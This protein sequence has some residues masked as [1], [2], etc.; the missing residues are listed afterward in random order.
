MTS[1]VSSYL[2]GK[3]I[4]RYKSGLHLKTVNYASSPLSP[5]PHSPTKRT[6]VPE[7]PNDAASV[8]R[9]QA[10][11]QQCGLAP[12]PGKGLSQ[13]KQELDPRFCQVVVLPQEQPELA[14]STTARREWQM[15]NELSDDTGT[16]DPNPLASDSLYLV[17]PDKSDLTR[18]AEEE[19]VPA[20]TMS[21]AG[22]GA[23]V[24]KGEERRISTGIFQSD[25]RDPGS[26]SEKSAGSELQ[27]ATEQPRLKSTKSKSVTPVAPQPATPALPLVPP[28]PVRRPVVVVME[29]LE[30]LIQAVNRIEDDESRRLT[31]IAFLS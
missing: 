17:H 15:E 9:R 26:D 5:P 27:P 3:L 2:L 18:N 22:F 13:L 6:G 21:S 12:R 23:F 31:E 14:E 10:A 29:D 19:K 7:P 8:Q 30:S 1:K 24:Q 20:T 11:L 4:T 25:G 28:S 16:N